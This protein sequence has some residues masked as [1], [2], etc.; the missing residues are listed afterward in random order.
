M[1]RICSTMSAAELIDMASR[2]GFQVRLRQWDSGALWRAD[3]LV[4]DG[5]R[6]TISYHA[7]NDMGARSPSGLL[8]RI[9]RRCI[10]DIRGRG[11]GAPVRR[12]EVRYPPL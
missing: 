12:Q 6:R 11:G 1:F 2:A 3:I 4:L 10:A 7:A 9:A 8:D 5:S